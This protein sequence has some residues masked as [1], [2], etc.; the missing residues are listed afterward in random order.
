MSAEAAAP[1]EEIFRN[2]VVVR[3]D[4]PLPPR[5]L[6]QLRLPKDAAPKPDAAA[7]AGT[8]SEGEES[9]PD[10]SKPEDSKPDAGKMAPPER[11]PEIT[12]IG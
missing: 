7:A 6:L 12:T 9:K 11:G 3:G 1:L 5:D 8:D 10:D 4:Q 2:V